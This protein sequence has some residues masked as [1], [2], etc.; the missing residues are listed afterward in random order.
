MGVKLDM[1]S[2]TNPRVCEAGEAIFREYDLGAEMYVLLEGEVEITIGN[3][4]V[5]TLGPGGAH[6]HR[7]RE[8]TLQA[9][10]H[11]RETFPLHGRAD[12]ALRPAD[13]EGDGRP[14]EEDER[15]PLV[16]SRTS[17]SRRWSGIQSRK[18]Q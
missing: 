6:R 1:F 15:P 9:R 13:H 12:A 3:N 4:V 5:E 11:P 14:A 18:V 2:E 17:Q 7:H 16:S 10:R 8:D